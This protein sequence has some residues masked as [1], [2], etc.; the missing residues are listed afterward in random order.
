MTP[1]PFAAPIL[2]QAFGMAFHY[3]P[4]PR[5]VAEPLLAAGT[6][7]VVATINGKPF[8]RGI[9]GGAAE[10]PYLVIG[11]PILRE[12]G[13]REDDV[14]IVEL[15][16]HPDPNAV[17]LGE[18]F[19]AALA[20]DDE[21]AERFRSM[22]PGLQRSLAYYVTSAKREETRIKRAIELTRK[23]RTRTLHGDRSDD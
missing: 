7:R 4:V 2:R 17:V 3:L 22:T 1:E 12:L 18:E 20:L 14:V 19:E 8:E 16:P 21:A 5:S 11:L 9:Q 6:R 23:L 13:V 15:E 10:E